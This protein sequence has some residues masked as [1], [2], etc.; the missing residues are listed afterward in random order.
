MVSIL[1]YIF[2]AFSV[3][4]ILRLSVK[5]NDKRI[6]L[7]AILLLTLVAGLRAPSV[8]VDTL[9]NIQAFSTFAN[10]GFKYVTREYAYYFIGGTIYKVFH[11]YSL[12][13][14]F[15][16]F[17]IYS[18]VFFRLWDFRKSI[19][20]G[21]AGFLFVLN[22]FGGTMN[23]IRQF[24]AI[25]IIFYGTRYL[26]KREYL[27]YIGFVLLAFMFHISS[28]VAYIFPLFYIGIKKKYKLNEF[29]CAIFVSFSSIAAALFLYLKYSSY[30]LSIN[31]VDFAVINFIRFIIL[32][33]SF[34]FSYKALSIKKSVSNEKDIYP[35]NDSLSFNLAFI[36]TFIGVSVGFA[37][38]IIDYASRVGYFFKFFEIVYYGMIFYSPNIN[39]NFK[40][41]LLFALFVLGV[42]YLY[43]YNGIIPYHTIFNF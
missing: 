6:I 33:I 8:G 28:C 35:F 7:I 21:I 30:L 23:G 39:K 14:M 40:M 16:G 32:I 29:I 31:E 5:R 9:S 1:F 43:F 19:D 37:N 34:L 2:L 3:S 24:V 18:L 22:Y 26:G 41:F 10:Y 27:K 36:F 38:T 20:L 15:Y 25:A 13:F 12:V 11:Q 17:L 4:G 42:Y